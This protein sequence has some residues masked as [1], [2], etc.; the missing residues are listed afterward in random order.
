MEG[1]A[2]P[3]LT[4][5]KLGNPHE[6]PLFYLI[7]EGTILCEGSGTILNIVQ[8]LMAVYYVC[9]LEYPKN[10]SYTCLFIQYVILGLGNDGSSKPAKLVNFVKKLGL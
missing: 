2:V 1:M 7:G 3:A 10:N 4:A 8:A 9:N 6:E 5:A